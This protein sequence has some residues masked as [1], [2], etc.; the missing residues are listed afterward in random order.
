MSSRQRSAA[1]RVA[2]WDKHYTAERVANIIR[3][4]KAK[5][6]ANN[7]DSTADLVRYEVLT[8]MEL[9]QVGVPVIDVPEYLAFSREVWAKRRRYAGRMLNNVV[10]GLI[11]KWTMRTLDRSVLERIR[12]NVYTIPAPA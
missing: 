8:K 4:E 5:M 10:Q 12:N 1:D 9:N 6:L 11:D 3:A 7:A 2:K